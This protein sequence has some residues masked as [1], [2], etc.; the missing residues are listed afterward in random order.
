MT[1]EASPLPPVLAEQAGYLASKLDLAAETPPDELLRQVDAAL[2][3]LCEYAEADADLLDAIMGVRA[4]TQRLVS[5]IEEPVNT[6]LADAQRRVLSAFEALLH[7][8]MRAR[9]SAMSIAM[10]LGW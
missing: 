9:P 1:E 6:D 10:G 4:A 5:A 3:N 2:L 8:L 7:V